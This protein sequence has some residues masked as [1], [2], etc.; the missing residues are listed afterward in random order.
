MLGNIH[1]SKSMS[2]EEGLNLLLITL[3]PFKIRKMQ[4]PLQINRFAGV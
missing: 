2:E 4:K 3:D 1:G